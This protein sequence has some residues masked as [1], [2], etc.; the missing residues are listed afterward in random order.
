MKGWH[1]ICKSINVVH[2]KN[3]MEDKNRITLT[4]DADKAFDKIQC[5]FMIKT[6]SKIG[7]EGTYLNIT[8]VIHDKPTTSIPSKGKNYSVPLKIRNKTGMSTFTALIQLLMQS[9]NKKNLIYF[10]NKQ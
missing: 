1:N 2:Y 6:L 7:L 8:K 5:P 10:C 3:K 9:P 4:I